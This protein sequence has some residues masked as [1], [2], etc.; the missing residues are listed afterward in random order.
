MTLEMV[1]PSGPGLYLGVGVSFSFGSSGRV[2]GS[3]SVSARG[4][5]VAAD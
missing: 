4:R 5:E 2:L 3:V 1:L